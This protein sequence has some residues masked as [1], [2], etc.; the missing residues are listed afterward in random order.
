[1]LYC[2]RHNIEHKQ[3]DCPQCLIE[4]HWKEERKRDEDSQREAERRHREAQDRDEDNQREA[5][6]RHQEIAEIQ[7]QDRFERANPGD[8]KCEACL[9][10]TLKKGASRCPRVVLTLNR[11]IGL[12]LRKLRNREE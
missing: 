7:E 10:I 1:M 5:E 12:T 11:D 2:F 3:A 6:R 8:Y 4:K 9:Y